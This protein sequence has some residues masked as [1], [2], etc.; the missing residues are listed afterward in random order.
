MS[1]SDTIIACTAIIANT[2]VCIVGM[3]VNARNNLS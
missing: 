2:I 3:W 1:Q